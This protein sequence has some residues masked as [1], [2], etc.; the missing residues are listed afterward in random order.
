MAGNEY[1]AKLADPRWQRKRLEIFN[2]DNWTCQHCKDKTT[3]LEIH[4]TEYWAGKQ[5]WDYPDDMLITVC[6]NC[7]GAEQVRFKH[8][9]YLLKALKTR[10]FLA[11]EILAIAQMVDTMDH[12]RKTLKFNIRT[13]IDK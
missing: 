7:H 5:P 8:E 2:R 1:S 13:F 9:E 10:G 6:R 11:Y 4:H 3:Q 12:F